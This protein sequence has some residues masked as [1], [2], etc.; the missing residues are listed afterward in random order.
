MKKG[1]LL[2]IGI[3]FLNCLTFGQVLSD[4]ESGLSSDFGTWT[5]QTWEGKGFK[6]ITTVADPTT[7]ATG[8]VMQV[9]FDGSLD[10]RG[11]CDVEKYPLDF[12][13][14]PVIGF[15][16]YLPAD[17]PSGYNIGLVGQDQNSWSDCG[18]T[19]PVSS[20]PKETWYPIY[21]QAKELSLA[22][23]N[24]DH[25][26]TSDKGMCKLLFK[27]DVGTSTTHADSAWAGNILVDD[28]TAYGAE[29]TAITDFESG[30]GGFSAITWKGAG[31]TG[32]QVVADPTTRAKGN[33][34]QIAFDGT[35]GST[36]AVDKEPVSADADIIAVWVYLPADIPSGYQIL[37]DGQDN[38]SWSDATDTINVSGILKEHGTRLLLM[39]ENLV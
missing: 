37:L 19:F 36:G 31:V 3:L 39:Q 23:S 25:A 26:F 17:I 22:N 11:M 34:Y 35:K 12:K 8:Q 24:F 1:I 30:S 28:I 10:Y 9:A 18:T 32:A 6:S 14:A 21:F 16:V 38:N 4:F 5:N 27:V 29:P 13:S 15:W 2:T 20:I 33:V 7:R